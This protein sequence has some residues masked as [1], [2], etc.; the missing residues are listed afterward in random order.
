[1]PKGLP[2]NWVECD[3]VNPYKTIFAGT[4]F[5]LYVTEDSG[6]T[7]IKDTRVPSTVVS[8][9]KIHRNKKDIYF[10]THGRG[11]FKGVINNNVVSVPSM[12]NQN[13]PKIFPIPATSVLN[14]HFKEIQI[15]TYYTIY[16][17]NGKIM[18]K[19]QLNSNKTELNIEKLPIG[20][21][22]IVYQ[23]GNNKGSELFLKF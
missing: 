1:L 3:P 9:I 12:V 17:I 16:D 5:G 21:Y 7:W 4:D 14:I 13:K 8:S 18:E 23:N 6:T 10:F 19:G 20:K 11:V 2:V 22:V 15:N